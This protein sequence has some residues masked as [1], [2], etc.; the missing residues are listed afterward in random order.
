[1]SSLQKV[2]PTVWFWVIS[3]VALL[4]N[5]MGVSAYLMEAYN[6]DAMY[7]EYSEAQL[8]LMTSLP[9]WIT[10]AFA[11]SVFAGAIGCLGLVLRKKWAT[12]VLIISFLAV[13]ARTIYFFFM[14]NG[15]ELF[16]TIEGTVLPIAVVV[17][18]ALLIIFSRVSKDRGWIS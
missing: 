12:P 6:K 16:G 4:W 10:G 9:A 5:L 3:I 1:M 7:A 8:N 11:T 2:K 17:V 15:T 13:L 18:A 14:T